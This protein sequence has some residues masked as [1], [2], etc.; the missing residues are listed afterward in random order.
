MTWF[1]DARFGLFIHWGVYAAA[2][3]HEWVKQRERLTD[4]QYQ[5]YAD[6]FDP[7]LYDPAAWAEEA[8]G[9]GMKYLVVTTKHHDGFCLWDSA[10]TDYKAT[11]TPWG[12]DLIR[13]L[14]DAFRARGLRTGLYYS[15]LDWHHPQFPVD[16]YHPRAGD[17]E[18][19][20]AQAGRDIAA[21]T[22]YLH[23]QVRELLTGYGQIDT[24]WFDFSYAGRG[25]G[26]KGPAEWQS[27]KL[28]AMV[29]ELQPGILI[30]N[31][32]G[33]PELADFTTPEQVMPPG[34]VSG[35]RP[36]EACQTLN[37]SWGYDRDNTGYKSAGQL[38]RMLVD[39]VSKDGNMLLNIGPNARGEFGPEALTRLREIGR[40]M[41][42]HSRA[43][44]G[45]GPAPFTPPQ[46]CRYTRRGDRLYLH[47]LSWPMGHVHLPGL[48][49]RV[50]YA[51]LLNDASEIPVMD[52]D[53]ANP[54]HRYLTGLPEDTLTLRLPP[55]PPDTEVPVIEMFLSGPDSL[56]E[57]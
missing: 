31:R 10:L 4:E 51:Q 20:A 8:A 16:L 28:A 48:R 39:T 33:V 2:A 46:D 5:K 26:A 19:T 41:R 29:R 36:W 37:G 53:P 25:T 55:R 13:P 40:W 18:F 21:Y 34:G 23:G 45:A 47:L 15:L 1:T 42:L 49:G 44:H 52:V 14:L 6:H 56:L 9:A 17:E 24:M 35:H 32:L 30:N 11:R 50:R 38:I 57:G 7:D 3:R 22:D 54:M 12:Q 43:I 27:E